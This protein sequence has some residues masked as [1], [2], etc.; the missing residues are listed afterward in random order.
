MTERDTIAESV[1]PESDRKGRKKEIFC[2]E[3]LIML[4]FAVCGIYGALKL[5]PGIWVN[6]IYWICR[7]TMDIR[8]EFYPNEAY[9]VGIIGGADGPTAIFLTTPVW[10]HY[11]VPVLMLIVGTWGFLRMRRCK[12]KS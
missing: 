6:V 9:S 8:S 12:G 7:W 10:I 1:C 5:L 4:L 11:A 3:N 2:W